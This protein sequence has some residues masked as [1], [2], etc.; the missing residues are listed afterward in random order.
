MNREVALVGCN[1]YRRDEVKIEIDKLCSALGFSVSRGSRILLKPNLV[2][3]VGHLRGAVTHPEFVAAVAS[4]CLDHGAR[5]VIGDSPAF[6]TA[7]QVMQKSGYL[8]ALEGLSVTLINLQKKKPVKTVNGFTVV[9]AGEIDECDLLINLPKIKAHDQLRLTMAVK[10][11]FGLVLSWR[12][13]FAHMQH[14]NKHFAGLIIDLLDH[15][16]NGISI[17]DGIFAMHKRGPV[18][19]QPFALS[20]IAAS[21]NPVALDAAVMDILGI[22]PRISPLWQEAFARKKIGCDLSELTFPLAEPAELAV[23]GFEV[24]EVL[25]P[26]RFQVHSFLFNSIRKIFS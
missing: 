8:E 9:L 4:W 1:T 26:I 7:V 12:K 13:A 21:A 15:V 14:G 20:L 16:P 23:Q 5:V 10:N 2:S 24:P 17:A 6:G 18:A 25:L 19:G 22:D 11:Y 3:A